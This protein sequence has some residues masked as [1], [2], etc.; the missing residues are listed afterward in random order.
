M[1]KS[2]EV[3]DKH[4]EAASVAAERLANA[5][6]VGDTG[7]AGN[8]ASCVL[9]HLALAEATRPE[10]APRPKRPSEVKKAAK[11]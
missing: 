3:S 5:E 2:Q 11:K 6:A 9:A 1:E 4:L 7:G 8:A 10:K